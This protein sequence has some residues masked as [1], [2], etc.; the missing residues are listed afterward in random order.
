M[1]TFTACCFTGHR[2]LPESSIPILRKRLQFCIENYIRDGGRYFAC[3]GAFGFDLLAAEEVLKAKQKYP[4]VQMILLLPYPGYTKYW[5]QED[6]ERFATVWPHCTY[7]Y[8]ADS[9]HKGV[10]FE[11]DRKLVEG[12]DTCICYLTQTDSSGTGYTVEQAKKDS[13]WI[14]NLADEQLWN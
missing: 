7:K 12:S 3:G 8:I 13:L 6:Q 5:K 10:Y 1:D 11:R 2:N 9:Y 14:C 4:Q